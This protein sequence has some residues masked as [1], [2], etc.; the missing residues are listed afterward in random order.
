MNQI[1]YMI[2]NEEEKNRIKSIILFFA[3]TII[4]F[5][6]VMTTM[7]GYR[8]AVS[9]AEREEQIEAA[10][11][12]NIEFEF[13][14]AT[15]NAIIK[16]S[17]VREVKSIIYSWN[18]EEEIELVENTSEDIKEYIELPAGTNTL[19]VKVTDVEGKTVEKSEE[20]TYKGTYM[21]VSV[22][23]SMRLR[24][25]VTDM[26]GLQSVTYRWN[27]EEEIVAYPDEENS[28][29]IEINSDIPV[30]ENTM[31]VR[32]VNNENKVE[33]KQLPV[34]GISRPTIKLSYNGE[35]TII[36]VK[37]NDD[38]GIQSYSYKLSR[39]AISEIA[40]N[41]KIISNFQEKLSEV[42][43][44]TKEGEGQ[45]SITEQ[46][47]FQEGFNYLEISVINIEGVEETYSGWCAK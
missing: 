32:A 8:I 39:A 3:I 24:I 14:E 47:E 9:I 17:H 38:Q 18:N 29:V 41:G 37:L 35:K 34:Q 23:D 25:V 11:I 31:T 40:E 13:E 5:G 15:N 30:G 42:T 28:T 26:T 1:L 19:N 12:P 7:G 22:I 20:F 43:S 4:I 33:E 36:T 21:E 6:I 10:K 16:V 27:S 44:Q 2:E 46:L 45:N